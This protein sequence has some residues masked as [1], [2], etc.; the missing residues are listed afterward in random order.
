MMSS[1]VATAPCASCS[2]PMPDGCPPHRRYCSDLCKHRAQNGR[3]KR[4]R[5]DGGIPREQ[6]AAYKERK[7]AQGRASKAARRDEVNAQSRAY[8]A[9]LYDQWRNAQRGDKRTAS[10]GYSGSL[11]EYADYRERRAM[12]CTR[13]EHWGA[14]MR[15]L[16]APVAGTFTLDQWETDGGTLR[17]IES[18]ADKWRRRYHTDPTFM[19]WERQRNQFKK[20]FKGEK[21]TNTIARTVGY[22]RDELRAHI[23]QRFLPGMSWANYGEWHVDH[24]RPK[25]QFDPT[26]ADDVRDC[27]ALSNLRPLWALD[28][29]RRPKDGSDL[30]NHEFLGSSAVFSSAR[31]GAA[32]GRDTFSDA[33]KRRP[34]PHMVAGSAA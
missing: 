14:W 32:A 6:T 24:V 18:D 11:E 29:L 25:N 34:P 28:N 2:G 1:N 3:V 30:H 13:A 15:A 7:R 19:V 33:G 22:T 16:A 5:A 20:W 10:P 12:G 8:R 31:G 26:N 17:A 27:W 9:R 23:E 21:R 4:R